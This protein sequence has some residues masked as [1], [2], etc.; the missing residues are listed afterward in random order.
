MPS[1]FMVFCFK[2]VP[3]LFDLIISNTVA[4]DSACICYFFFFLKKGKVKKPKERVTQSFF[5][6][7][8]DSMMTSK[9]YLSDMTH[10]FEVV[11]KAKLNMLHF[12]LKKCKKWA[13]MYMSL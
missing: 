5:L 8:E 9:R 6:H 4:W 7:W 2:H 12:A 11:E 3:H 13:R 1:D 10:C